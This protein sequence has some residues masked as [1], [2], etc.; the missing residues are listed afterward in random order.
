MQLQSTKKYCDEEMQKRIADATT[1]IKSAYS[2]LKTGD[3]LQCACR[4]QELEKF[5]KF[6]ELEMSIFAIESGA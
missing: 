5:G 1:L 3:F 6:T 4:L 2:F